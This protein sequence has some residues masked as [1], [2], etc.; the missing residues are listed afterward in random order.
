M[1]LK[2]LYKW[3]EDDAQKNFLKEVAVLRSLSHRNVLRFIGVLYKDKKLHLITEYVAGGTL[4]NLLHGRNPYEPLSWAERIH[5]A[6]DIS[7]GMAYLHSK[8]LIHRDLNSG[9]CLVRHY[10]SDRTVIVADFGLARLCK[11]SNEGTLIN[12]KSQRERRKRYTVVGTP[13]Y[14]VK[15]NNI[16]WKLTS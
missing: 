7:L 6:R 14:D 1:V 4:A 12:K 13:W 5:F 11:A 2:E 3:V 9:N 15:Y 16:D 10:G 8:N